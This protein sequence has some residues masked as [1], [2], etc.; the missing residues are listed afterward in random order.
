MLFSG[1]RFGRAIA[2]AG[3][4]TAAVACQRPSND[5]APLRADYPL[6][7][8]TEGVYIIQGPLGFP[9]PENQ[10]FMSNVGVIVTPH[11]VVVVDPGSSKQ[12]AEMALRKMATLTPAPVIGVFN[13]HIHGDHW[14]GNG[15]IHAAAP[16]AVFYA[17][18][19][20]LEQARTGAGD[21]WLNLMMQLTQGGA[22]GT[23]IK[24]P[25]LAV[26]D[27]DTITIGGQGFRIFHTG[28]AHTDGDIMIEVIG[29]GVLFCGDNLFNG[30][31]PRLDDGSFRGNIAALDVAL[32]TRAQ[33]F[34]P[35]HGAVGG[36]ELPESFRRFLAIIL[37]TVRHEYA[38]GRADVDMR[39]AVLQQL[40]AYR[41]WV[42]LDAGLGRL[43]SIAYLEV[44][45]DAF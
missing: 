29:K 26:D 6:T 23:Q 13:T 24:P 19:Q 32:K 45:R 33:Y 14:L 16:H 10:G 25:D 36:R 3:F 34:V 20:M 43:I 39:P 40:A 15:A 2:L 41:N 35:G 28:T 1:S 8:I 38:R 11:G 31:T 5:A 44:E 27:G 22:R 12:V 4:M 9:N 37:E 7:R 17:H 21:E 18:R 42:D 30:R